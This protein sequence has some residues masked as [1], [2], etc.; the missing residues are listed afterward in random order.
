MEHYNIPLAKP[1]D[2][3]SS[4]LVERR[5]RFLTRCVH[6]DSPEK[7]RAFV[8][9]IRRE[10][11]DA[12]HNCWAFVAGPPGDTARIGSSDDGEPHGTAG[13]P[14]LQVLLHS[15][16][17]EI[18]AV[19]SRWFGGI[20]LGTGGL[21]RAYQEAVAQ[22]LATLPLVPRLE[23]A[24]IMVELDYSHA[25][26]LR[27]ALPHYEAEIENEHYSHRVRLTLSLPAGRRTELL[28]RLSQV[29]NGSAL[30]LE[31]G[32]EAGSASI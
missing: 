4:S 24:R 30:L 10:Q 29:S 20:K 5:S 26:S 15:G 14:M 13:R 17:G 28:S 25:D 9:R 16:I 2:P 32:N 18:C 7:A 11:P 1:D 27:R 3:H 21:V 19:V 12:S 22:N 8:D 31:P 23:L 6:A